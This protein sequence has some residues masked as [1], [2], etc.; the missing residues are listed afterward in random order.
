MKL[1]DVWSLIKESGI[2]F[3]N[4]KGPR[5]G[6]A[7]AFYTALSLSPL[8][9]VVIAIAGAA[10]GEEA[11]RGEIA[12]QIRD[13]VGEE[14]AQA[15]QSILAN[16]RSG[17]KSAMMTV[18]GVITLLVGA[19]G[20]FAQLQDALDTVWNVK[21]ERVGG[22]IWGA[23]RDRLI[24]F[25]VVCGMAFLLLVSLVFSAV[26]SAVN[27]WLESRLPISGEVI[28]ILNQVVSFALTT[29]LF[30]LIFKVLPH[31][32]PAWSDVWTG[33]LITAGLFTIGKY[34]IGLYLGQAAPGSAYGAAGSFVVLLVWIYYST[35]ILL[36]GA[37]ITQ[38]YAERHG[39]G[40]RGER[41]EAAAPKTKNSRQPVGSRR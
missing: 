4:D 23:I 34:L 26:L 15:I 28:Q 17:G 25:S 40:T 37:E 27:G 31:A 3:W 20:V 10:F 29:A 19:S 18:V 41:T 36:F 6:A 32:R 21:P 12:H 39:H 22:G 13:T 16:N 24:S 5:L 11:A 1:G 30:A 35:Q 7:L 33:A 14:G 8:L 38:V 2:Q 9:V